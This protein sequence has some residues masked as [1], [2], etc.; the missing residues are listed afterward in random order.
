MKKKQK[1][2]LRIT[3]DLSDKILLFFADNLYGSA[4]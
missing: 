2:K 3:A 1:E 4:D